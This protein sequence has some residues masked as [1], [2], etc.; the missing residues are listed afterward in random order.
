M[1]RD[2]EH[3]GGERE[4]RAQ[5]QRFPFRFHVTREQESAFAVGDS[6]HQRVIIRDRL[7]ESIPCGRVDHLQACLSKAPQAPTGWVA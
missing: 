2:L 3:L 7:S 1:M 5:N 4:A 6:Q